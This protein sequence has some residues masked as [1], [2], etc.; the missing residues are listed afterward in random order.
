MAV[1]ANIIRLMMIIVAAEVFGQEAGDFV[2]RNGF[3]SILPYLPAIAGVLLVGRWLREK[4][5]SAAAPA[6]DSGLLV[7]KAQQA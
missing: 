6:D 7:G 2:H 1:L 3:F 5:P 4:K